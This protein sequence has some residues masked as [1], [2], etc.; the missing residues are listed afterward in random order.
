MRWR[1]ATSHD[2][3]SE[4]LASRARPHPVR[5]GSLGRLRWEMI[6][7]QMRYPVRV[8]ELSHGKF[9]CRTRR[10]KRH[11]YRIRYV[12]YVVV[13]ETGDHQRNQHVERGANGER[14]D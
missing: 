1:N 10:G 14:C 12:Q 5:R 2:A 9:A 6:G 3:A 4:D 7:P 8:R 11:I 13:R